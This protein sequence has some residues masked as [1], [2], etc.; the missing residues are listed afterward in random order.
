MARTFAA[1]L[2]VVGLTLVVA[3]C[4]GGDGKSSSSGPSGGSKQPRVD[5]TAMN[6]A[7]VRIIGECV[8]RRKSG[9]TGPP[10]T[11]F[12]RAVRVL[13]VNFRRA[14]D[15]KF[16]RVPKANPTTMR[17]QLLVLGRFVEASC[18]AGAAGYG[19]SLRGTAAH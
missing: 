2:S 17:A 1:V 14:P 3:A 8:R 9:A 7:R 19:R 16:R 13:K 15:T 6:R 18:G 12:R 4:G 10:S 11:G 5:V